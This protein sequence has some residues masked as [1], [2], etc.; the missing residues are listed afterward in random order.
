MAEPLTFLGSVGSDLHIPERFDKLSYVIALVRTQC[1]FYLQDTAPGHGL[2]SFPF[3]STRGDRG[4][5]INDQTRSVLHQD[6]PHVAKDALVTLALLVDQALRIRRRGVRF[7][8]PALTLEVDGR[9]APPSSGGF[10]EPSFGRKIFIEGQNATKKEAGDHLIQ[11]PIPVRREGRVVP[12]LPIQRQPDKPTVQQIEVDLLD[13]LPF[14]ANSKKDL[15]QTGSKQAFRRYRAAAR[16]GIKRREFGVH[17]PQQKVNHFAELSN[18]MRG[19]YSLFQSTV[20]EQLFLGDI[21]AAHGEVSKRERLIDG[22]LL[23]ITNAQ[24]MTPT[25]VVARYK[26]LADIE[27]GFRVLKNELDIVPMHHRLP[28]RI[29]SHA[30]LCFL[31]LIMHRI[32]RMRLQDKNSKLSPERVLEIAGRIQWHEASLQGGKKLKGVSRLSPQQMDLFATIDV[33]VPGE[34]EVEPAL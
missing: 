27:R 13:Q 10:P 33:P 1:G 2:R 6:M 12:H 19:R 4:F 31:A 22:K 23:L 20:A 17:A 21:G 29:K 34:K 28:K 25:E 9:V 3:R 26:S 14:R 18:G 11:Q 16:L 5:G 7:I 24:D 15:Q 8:A 30:M 32:L